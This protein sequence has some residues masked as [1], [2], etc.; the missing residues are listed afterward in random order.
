MSKSSGI[1]KSG[2]KLGLAY[3][4]HFFVGLIRIPIALVIYY[5]LWAS[6]YAYNST[7]VI[8]G[9][10]F[11]DMITYYVMSMIVAM[12]IWCDIETWM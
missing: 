12:F 11:Q 5:F 2:F 7:P 9:F 6:I 8:K 3:R 10:T 1:I 4:F